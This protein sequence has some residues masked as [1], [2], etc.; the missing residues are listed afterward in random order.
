MYSYTSRLA[1][2]VVMTLTFAACGDGNGTIPTVTAPTPTPAPRSTFA[3][4]GVVSEVTANG[5]VPVEGGAMQVMSCD[6]SVRHGCGGNG[7]ILGVTTNGK[8]DYVVDGVYPGAAVVW[9]EKPGFQ[10]P[11]GVKVDGEGAQT[12]TVNGD[13][14]LDVQLVRR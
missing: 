11:V 7:S 12:V 13:T 8:G 6:P 14:R 4:F 2:A 9:V 1:A 3:V 5:I 10:L